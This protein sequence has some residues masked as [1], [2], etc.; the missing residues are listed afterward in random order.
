M[1]WNCLV[2]LIFLIGKIP[3]FRVDLNKKIFLFLFF[4]K[5][6]VGSLEISKEFK[7]T[8]TNQYKIVNAAEEVANTSN[9]S[10]SKN[11]YR[12]IW[13]FFYTQIFL[14]QSLYKNYSSKFQPVS[15]SGHEIWMAF[16]TA[17]S[18]FVFCF[19]FL[20]Y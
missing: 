7:P 11:I 3:H 10:K 2:F 13:F 4:E 5:D 14:V 12:W 20:F 19:L 18:K 8:T 16:R 6:I 17:I 9:N 1:C 15:V